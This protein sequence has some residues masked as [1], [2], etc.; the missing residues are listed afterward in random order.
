[1]FHTISVIG[2]DLRQ[3]TI[4]K[5]LKKEGFHIFLHG[6]DKYTDDTELD[7]EELDFVLSSDIIILPVPVTFDGCTVN[8]PY[9]DTPLSIDELLDGVNPSALVFGGQIKPN[10]QNALN[11]KS[12]KYCDYL[13]REELAVRNAI[14]VELQKINRFYRH[15]VVILIAL[16]KIFKKITLSSVQNNFGIRLTYNNFFYKLRIYLI[17]KKR[18]YYLCMQGIL[19][20]KKNLP[21]FLKLQNHIA[22][23]FI[24]LRHLCNIYFIRSIRLYYIQPA[25][26]QPLYFCI[27]ISHSNNIFFDI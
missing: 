12:I 7:N 17:R 10:L 16:C 20:F 1:M 25:F 24:K 4:G 21:V 5:E 23:P 27:N 19:C 13:M 15:A 14:P 6:F 8:S 26:V 18:I 9:S 3:L 2:G 22:I 11:E